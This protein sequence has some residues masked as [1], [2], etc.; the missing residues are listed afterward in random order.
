MTNWVWVPIVGPLTVFIFLLFPDGRLLSPRWRVVAWL[1]GLGIALTSVSLAI[2]PGQLSNITSV[3]NPYGIEALE[4]LTDTMPLDT[5]SST[6]LIPGI[7]AAA[8]SLVPRYRRA[9]TEMRQ[10]LKWL[11][12]AAA[13]AVIFLPLQGAFLGIRRIQ[14]CL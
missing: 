4:S 11:A 2:Y 6:L 12:M 8:A 7:V 14:R 13:L 1:G 9:S 10:Q 3:R 5:A